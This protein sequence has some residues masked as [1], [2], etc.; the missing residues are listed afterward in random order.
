M[1][2]TAEDIKLELWL[3]KRN[4]GEI[5]IQTQKG[6]LIP[7]KKGND[8]NFNLKSKDSLHRRDM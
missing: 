3:R 6:D 8:F 1:I 7:I 5:V 4:Y 2:A